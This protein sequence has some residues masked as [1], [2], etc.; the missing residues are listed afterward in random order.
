MPHAR[1]FGP[2]KPHSIASSRVIAPTPMV[3]AL[4]MRFFMT[5]VSYSLS[6]LGM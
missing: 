4:T 2:V 5:I 3:R 6:R 1:K